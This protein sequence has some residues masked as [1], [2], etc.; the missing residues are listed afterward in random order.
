MLR[1]ISD[2][3]HD[4]ET[5][6]FLTFA[7]SSAQKVQQLLKTVLPQLAQRDVEDFYDCYDHEAV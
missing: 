2:N 5:V 3:A 7:Q 6:D 4:S 1:T